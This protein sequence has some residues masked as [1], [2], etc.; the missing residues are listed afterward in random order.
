MDQEAQAARP[1]EVPTGRPVHQRGVGEGGGKGT[2]LTAKVKDVQEVLVT[3]GTGI[4]ALIMGVVAGI[5]GRQNGNSVDT[6]RIIASL[7]SL[8]TTVKANHVETMKVQTETRVDIAVIRAL[9]ERR[10]GHG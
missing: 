4:G 8:K 9:N 7:D 2:G 3:V 1:L 6:D 10:N 5:R